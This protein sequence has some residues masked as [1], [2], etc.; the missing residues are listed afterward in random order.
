[1]EK[2][3]L[4]KNYSKESKEKYADLRFEQVKLRNRIESFLARIENEHL[5]I[6]GDDRINLHKSLRETERSIPRLEAKIKICDYHSCDHVWFEGEPL[7]TRRNVFC[8]RCGLRPCF[9]DEALTSETSQL[10][11][12]GSF[13][14]DTSCEYLYLL[15]INSK[16]KDEEFL[17]EHV[18]LN[19]M[20]TEE[21]SISQVAINYI[22]FDI[23]S[24]YGEN[25]PA[26]EFRKLFVEKM[27]NFTFPRK[28]KG[29]HSKK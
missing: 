16:E 21:F 18:F 28:P 1:M 22:V 24:N 17:K 9:Y 29:S 3:L 19:D 14:N 10:V 8:V 4:D 2:A 27:K 5:N 11:S 15:G 6:N 12:S 7:N 25:L 20:I 13:E 26:E 23:T